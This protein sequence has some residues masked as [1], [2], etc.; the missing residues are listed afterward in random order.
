M[1][2]RNTVNE[3]APSDAAA[4]SASGSSSSNTGW[5]DRTA[6]GSVTKARATHMARRVSAMSRWIGTARTVEAQKRQSC[7]HR[8]KGERQVDECSEE[9]LA[10]EVV[11]H[12]D[13][14]D[15]HSRE[16]VDDHHDHRAQQRELQS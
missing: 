2:L 13:P 12:E 11:A 16:G 4:S 7:N 14:G 3:L 5:I 10:V 9:L 15:G 6:N 1:I 8:R